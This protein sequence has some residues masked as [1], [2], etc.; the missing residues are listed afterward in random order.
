I[1]II[2]RSVE[3][4]ISVWRDPERTRLENQKADEIKLN[5]YRKKTKILSF[6]AGFILGLLSAL[7]GVRVLEHLIVIPEAIVIPKDLPED[8]KMQVEAFRNLD[9]LLTSLTIAGGSQVFH[10]LISIF[11]D[12]LGQT[13]EG[14]KPS[15]GIKAREVIKPDT[16][17]SDSN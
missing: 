11:T 9:I 14:I 16:A 1:L 15:E 4:F 12:F 3:V 6:Y 2:E 7:A 13:R 17:N 10:E 8:L 5:S